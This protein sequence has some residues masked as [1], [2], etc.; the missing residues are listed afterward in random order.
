LTVGQAIADIASDSE[1]ELQNEVL[2]PDDVEVAIAEQ[3]CAITNHNNHTMSTSSEEA[4]ETEHGVK[5]PL[6]SSSRTPIS[7]PN[8]YSKTMTE[9]TL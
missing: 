3:Y 5:S 2:I 4:T 8:N 1:D 6:L 9:S 7:E